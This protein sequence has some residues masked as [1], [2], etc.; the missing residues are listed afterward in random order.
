MRITFTLCLPR[1]EASV[2]VVRRLCGRALDDLG[3][4]EDCGN[5]IGIALTE[6][7]SNVLKH[8]NGTTVQYE[9]TI[10]IDEK[11]CEIKVFDRGH[12]FDLSTVATAT[13]QEEAGRGIQLMRAL[14]DR[15]DFETRDGKGTVVHLVKRL[16]LRPNALLKRL[17]SA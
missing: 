17:A 8:A 16:Q 9:V 14:V 10:A 1:D 11:T 13:V 7:C 3:I 6:A 15:L 4:A 2:P 5:D 12:G